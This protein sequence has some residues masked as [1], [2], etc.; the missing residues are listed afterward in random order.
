MRFMTRFDT[1]DLR[2]LTELQAFDAMVNFLEAYW[3]MRGQSS[4]DIANL[5]SDLTRDVWSTGMP[6]DPA[7]WLDWQQ[8]VTK[9][10]GEIG[11]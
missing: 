6:G 5:L 7:N 9:V 2:T 4:D 1:T 8:A 3:Q 11:S 10:L